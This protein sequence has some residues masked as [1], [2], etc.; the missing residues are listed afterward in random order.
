MQEISNINKKIFGT[1]EHYPR[2]EMDEKLNKSLP[3][4]DRRA[5]VNWMYI[6]C[7]PHYIIYAW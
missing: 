5:R 4:Y 3:C 6:N 1:N 2:W 7:M